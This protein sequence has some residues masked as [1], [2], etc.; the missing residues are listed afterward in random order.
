MQAV[1][2]LSVLPGDFRDLLATEFDTQKYITSL[3]R[4]VSAEV[5]ED[6]VE[7][8]K[9]IL[10]SELSNVVN[11]H[12]N[13][14]SGVASS[15]SRTVGRYK[16]SSLMFD[17]IKNNLKIVK[18]DLIDLHL[19]AENE[20][21]KNKSEEDTASVEELKNECVTFLGKVEEFM[22]D[23]SDIN[24]LEN[25]SFAFRLLKKKLEITESGEENKNEIS[26][27][28]E[29]LEEC[30]T[31]LAAELLVAVKKSLWEIDTLEFCEKMEKNKKNDGKKKKKKKKKKV[32]CVDT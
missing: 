32:L 6:A 8:Q 5:L 10:A 31:S 15:L 29:K 28:L 16:S 11:L 7:K 19:E 30:R 12:L 23:P 24:G 3:K 22:R 20:H 18:K 27:L 14:V 21:Q 9:H 2:E 25:C 13:E 17:A 4:L 26:E 1:E